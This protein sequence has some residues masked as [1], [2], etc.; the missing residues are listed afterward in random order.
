MNWGEHKLSVDS[1]K[2]LEAVGGEEGE[3]GSRRQGAD[4]IEAQ[5]Q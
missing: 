1:R 5:R 4:R 3:D 2:E